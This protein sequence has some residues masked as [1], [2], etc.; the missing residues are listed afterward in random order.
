MDPDENAGKLQIHDAFHSILNVGACF[1]RGNTVGEAPTVQF[2][3]KNIDACYH[4]IF[5]P[6]QPFLFPN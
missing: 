2:I 6:L 3:K 4:L 5:F 1:L